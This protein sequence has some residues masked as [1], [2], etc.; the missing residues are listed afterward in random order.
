[1]AFNGAAASSEQAQLVEEIT[2]FADRAVIIKALQG[3]HGNVDKVVNEFYEGGPDKVGP[4][5]PRAFS[6]AQRPGC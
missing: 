2:G 5:P 6:V 1:M 4:S 3:N